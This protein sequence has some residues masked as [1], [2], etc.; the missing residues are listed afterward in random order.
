MTTSTTQLKAGSWALDTAHSSVSFAIRHL[1]ISKV[2]GGFTRFDTEFVVDENGEATLGA[3]IHLDSFDSGNPDRDA[4]VRTADFL[5]VENRPTLTFRALG[6]V[7]VAETFTVDGEVTLGA[8]TKPV[9]LDV[10]WGG[11]QAFGET[12]ER[13]AGFSA[14]G[15]I[16][17]SD[18]GVGPSAPGFLGDAVAIEL[19][20]QLVEPK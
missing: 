2:R 8:I 3:T 9:R 14:T 18:F 16:K 6:P 15:T 19:E 5:D 11:V 1:G 7:R 4:H 17:R 20:I 10:E 12:G 13:H